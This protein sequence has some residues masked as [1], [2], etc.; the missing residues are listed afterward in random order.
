[1][2]QISYLTPF[3]KHKFI[4][5]KVDIFWTPSLGLS[6]FPKTSVNFP[7][8]IRE[9]GLKSMENLLLAKWAE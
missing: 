2:K 1:M 3:A 5:M 9:P 6:L 4:V 7:K 8:K